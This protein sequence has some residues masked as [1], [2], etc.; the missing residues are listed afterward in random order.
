MFYRNILKKSFQEITWKNKYL[1]F[2]GFFALFLGASGEV[3]IALRTYSGAIGKNMLDGL[4]PFL[5]TGVFSLDIFSNLFFAIK[6]NPLD[7]MIIS[8]ALVVI[9]ILAA[10]FLWLA[11]V[12]Q[13]SLVNNS[14]KIIS[15][16][17]TAIKDG[18]LA[19]LENFWPVLGLNIFI[20][21]AIFI[22]LVLVGLPTFFA[23][24]SPYLSWIYVLLFVIFVSMAIILGLIF[25][26][27]I[28][29]IVIKKENFLNS[30]KLGWT[31]FLENWLVSIEMA[32]I[33]LAINLAV[34]SIALL[35]GLLFIGFVLFM[36]LLLAQ[37]LALALFW[38]VLSIGFLIG[39]VL[40]LLFQSILTTFYI[41][42]WTTLFIELIG[43][44]GSSKIIRI[45]DNWN[46]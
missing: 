7:F 17:E 12:C 29:Y 1:W 13:V 19:G 42:S 37:Y 27:S 36:A 41:S 8:F 32:L 31:L 4:Q 14:A 2:F 5:S 15:K 46:K 38:I 35:F 39:F 44:K 18:I 43:K 45:V 25:R 23:F 33:L 9:L 26:Y 30:L 34:Y 20:K 21:G 11:V 28:A 24:T 6:N 40:L 22:S 16:K 10:F 3:E